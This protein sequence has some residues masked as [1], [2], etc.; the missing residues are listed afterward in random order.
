LKEE[1]RSNDMRDD[2][3]ENGEKERKTNQDN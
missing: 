1:K 3:D 2:D